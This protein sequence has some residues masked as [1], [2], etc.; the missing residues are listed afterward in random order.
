MLVWKFGGSSVG[1]ADAFRKVVHIVSEAAKPEEQ[2]VVVASA[3]SGVTNALIEGAQAA[4]HGE[5]EHYQRIKAELLNKH[6]GTVDE[7]GLDPQVRL[8][9]SSLVED[10]LHDFDRFCRSVAILRELTPRGLDLISSLGERLS[11][12]ILAGALNTAG[13]KAQ[14]VEATELIVTDDSFGQA[15]PLMAETRNRTTKVLGPLLARGIVPVV[16]GFIGATADGVT[17]TLGRGGSDYTA[18]ILGACLSADEILIS[19]DVDGIMTADPRIVSDAYTLPKMTYTEAGELAYFGA[20]VLHPKT[21]QPAAEQNIP[22][23]AVNTFNPSHPGTLLVPELEAGSSPTKA[24]TVIK[25]LSLITVEGRGMLGVPGI[26]ARTFA[27]VARR[28]VNVLMISQSSSEQ[29][30]C[31]VVPQARS[32]EVVTSLEE[33]LRLEIHQRDIDN[34]RRQDDVAIVA[35]VGVGISRTPSVAAQITGALGRRGINIAV[36]AHGSSEANFSMVVSLQEAD[37]A[38]RAIHQDVVAPANMR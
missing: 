25:D 12:A 28:G 5:H 17:T 10:R 6:L 34:I 18:A 30:I 19:S 8:D 9:V 37:E 20:K 13:T 38:V 29:H 27:A 16:T 23:R 4:A 3:M 26:A 33:E 35:A 32:Q 7:L 2:V 11:V 15:N 14:A 36:I 24:V 22:L 1:S 21:I 31:F